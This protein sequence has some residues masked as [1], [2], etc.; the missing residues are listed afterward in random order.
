MIAT[1]ININA[2]AR[3]GSYVLKDNHRNGKATVIVGDTKLGDEICKSINYKSGNSVNFVISFASWENS[4]NQTKGREIVKD[5]MYE[6]MQGFRDDEYHMDIVEHNDTANL[7]YH[8]RVPKLNLLTNTQLKLYW[9]RSDLAYKKA[10]IDVIADRYNLY[11]GDDRRHTIKKSRR[12]S[13]QIDKWRGIE[14]RSSLDLSKKKGRSRAEDD[15]TNYFMDSIKIG[16]I[17]NLDDIKSELISMGFDIV[18]EGYDRGKKFDYLTIEN[19]SGKL[20]IKGDIYGREFYKYSSKDRAEKIESNR[21]TKER[22]SSNRQGRDEVGKTL[23]RER[24]KRL[25]FIDIQYGGARQRAIKRVQES[26]RRA[27]QSNKRE[28]RET[29]RANHLYIKETAQSISTSK[30]QQYQNIPYTPKVSPTIYPIGRINHWSISYVEDSTKQKQEDRP[31]SIGDN[32]SER[33]YRLY[34]DGRFNTVFKNYK[35]GRLDDTVRAEITDSL[36]DTTRGIYRRVTDDY[37][38]LQAEYGYSNE[39]NQQTKR[40]IKQIQETIKQLADKYKSRAVRH[41]TERYEQ[42]G[43]AIQRADKELKRG[44]KKCSNIYQEFEGGVKESIIKVRQLAV[45]TI[46][47]ISS[48][49]KEVRKVRRRGVRR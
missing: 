3:W 40:A 46:D 47:L 6:F 34:K 7:H 42:E 8:I 10:I 17:D 1:I 43:E 28:L 22:S 5:F 13:E 48:R 25:Q 41:I 23:Q 26:N 37:Q 33:W 49:V 38:S 14:E 45:K 4:V 29:D 12:E 15:I 20:R 44:V 35:G 39:Y 24:K 30:R 36:R 27:E 21:S 9:H 32:K 19:E 2:G 16:L 31:K 11:I 18:N